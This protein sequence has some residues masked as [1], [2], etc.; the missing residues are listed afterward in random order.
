MWQRTRNT[1]AHGRVRWSYAFLTA[2]GVAVVAA[3]CVHQ[4]ATSP[5]PA[6]Y[7][8]RM[9]D[10]RVAAAFEAATPD[11]SLLPTAREWVTHIEED[12]LPYWTTP[13][14]LGSPVGNFPTFRANDGSVIDPKSPGPDVTRIATRET[15]LLNRLGRQY[16]RTMSR[17]IFA[18]C[19][20]YHMTG[21]EQYLRWA[22][23]G[24]DYLFTKMVDR[25]GVFYSW[26]ENGVPG[27]EN[28]RQRISQDMAYALM[29]PAM[30]Y[31]LT[32][33]P[34]VLA[35]IRRTKD[36]IFASYREGNALRWINE[37]FVDL[38]EKNLPTQK[39]LVAQLDQINGYMLLMTTVLDGT[40]RRA[41]VDEMVMLAN[42]MREEYYDQ[43]Q[44]QFWGRIDGVEHK[45]LGQ[46]H[47]DFGHT[48]KTLWM[49]LEI[50]LR[51]DKPGLS[52]FALANM[53]R[54]FRE[55]YSRDYDT[56]IEKKL[57]N[58]ALGTDRIW[59]LHNEL[60]QTAAVLSMDDPSYLRYL[61][62]AYRYWFFEFVDPKGKE[63]WH[64][65]TGDPGKPAQP[66]L[67]KAHLWKNAFHVFEHALVG[68]ITGSAVRGEP[69]RLYYAFA[70][71]PPTSMIQPYFFTG[72]IGGIDRSGH[73]VLGTLKRTAVDFTRVKP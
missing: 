4:L 1:P 41:W 38:E 16:T 55:A 49:M 65:L 36:Y 24:L 48:I 43:K 67:L 50:G 18:Y 68:Y 39:E 5:A 26:V 10:V 28:A 46:P 8:S 30:Y 57:E 40:E 61:I 66:M 69:V 2:I 11:P 21:N 72:T 15:W 60:D 51:F 56:W 3:A 9:R 52:D 73:P 63:V 31:Y 54:V 35:V 47:V 29:G 59:W 70:T 13:V 37:A 19:I 25:D 42:T 27:P 20:A 22:R 32:R 17:Q 64:G 53:P 7:R 71:E 58:G 33:D 34:S 12:L 6:D 62:P 45:R 23:L 44:N 14:A